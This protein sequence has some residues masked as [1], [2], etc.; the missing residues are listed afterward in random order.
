[1]RHRSAPRHAAGRDES[2]R[3]HLRS[4]CS[5]LRQLR[6][7][8]R[9][10]WPHPWLPG[11]PV[12]IRRAGSGDRVAHEGSG[13]EEPR[14]HRSG[15]F[16]AWRLIGNHSELIERETSPPRRPRLRP[17]PMPGLS[18]DWSQRD[19]GDL[20]VRPG[21]RLP[22]GGGR[23]ARPAATDREEGRPRHRLV[24]LPQ[25][26]PPAQLRSRSSRLFVAA[27]PEESRPMPPASTES[28]W[29]PSGAPGH[30]RVASAYRP[31]GRTAHSRTCS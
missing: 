12:R 19:L 20:D 25:Q 21:D 22:G 15:P 8:A 10:L 13:Q 24:R 16:G 3:T 18:V 14:Q 29:S 11:A 28:W 9:T 5:R 2:I 6:G 1:V 7:G 31:R 4:P 26:V 30:R 23:S 17:G 27:L